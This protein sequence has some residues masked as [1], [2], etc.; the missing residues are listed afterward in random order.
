MVATVTTHLSV[1]AAEPSFVVNT[2]WGRQG[3]P[4]LGGY[5]YEP[6]PEE[7]PIF[8]PGVSAALRLIG[9]PGAG[10]DLAIKVSFREIG[11]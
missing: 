5:V 7:R 6:V 2:E 10:M 9:A 8:S 1:T 11:G 4:T 3:W